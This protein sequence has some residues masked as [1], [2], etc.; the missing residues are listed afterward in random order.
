MVT[1]RVF[2]ENI[3]VNFS[4]VEMMIFVTWRVFRGRRHSSRNFML[5]RVIDCLNADLLLLFCFVFFWIVFFPV[6]LLKISCRRR[7]HSNVFCCQSCFITI[8]IINVNFT[9]LVFFLGD[10]YVSRIFFGYLEYPMR[11]GLVAPSSFASNS[12]ASFELFSFWRGPR[13]I[14]THLSWHLSNLWSIRQRTNLFQFS[15]PV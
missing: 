13:P 15:A 10:E 5:R 6:S 8:I 4:V 3:D 7:R 11:E 9:P 2:K 14:Q 12:I 1:R